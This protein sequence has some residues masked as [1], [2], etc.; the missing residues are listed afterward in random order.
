MIVAHESRASDARA[1][2]SGA[3]RESEGRSPRL[4]WI[5]CR[6]STRSAAC[7]GAASVAGG[8]R[9][10]GDLR[11]PRARAE[12]CLRAA[13][14]AALQFSFAPDMT[15]VDYLPR[16]PR[17]EVIVHL[18]SLGIAALR[19]RAEAAARQDPR[20]WHRSADAD[21]LGRVEGDELGRAR[22][23]RPVRDP[24]RRPSGSAAHPD[25]RRLGRA[26]GAEGLSGPDQDDAEG[27]RAAAGDG[28]GVRG[29]PC[30]RTATARGGTRRMS[31]RD[32]A[33]L[34]EKAFAA[35][36]ALHERMRAQPRA[37]ARGGAGDVGRDHARGKKLPGVRQ[38][39][40]RV[41]RAAPVGRAGGTV[42]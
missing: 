12:V 9:H 16:E 29:Q 26:S 30:R 7:R 39:R 10:A 17:F 18:V 5:V 34:A 8:R 20:A 2:A 36:I 33:R 19:R 23:L 32:G 24:V 41:G 27:I 15:G 28:A 14:P 31:A 38:R 22:G 3:G 25:A 13:R 1:M 42:S 40:Q 4:T 11:R 6:F 37:D 21:A 35:T